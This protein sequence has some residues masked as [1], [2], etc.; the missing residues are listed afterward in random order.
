MD[1]SHV[2]QDIWMLRFAVGQAYAVR[3]PEG[4][5]LVDC[6]SAGS[7]GEI[8]D[9]LA[10][11][12]CAPGELRDIVLTHSHKDHTGA[13]AAVATA[14]GARVLA[15]AA[16]APVIRGDAPEP[17]PVLLDFEV[18]LYE[19]IA[20]TV[21]PAPPSP[22]HRELVD[23]DTLDWGQEARIV[24]VPGHT[25]GSIAVHLPAAGV[26]FTGDTIA[27]H[28]DAVILGVFNVDREQAVASF[29]RQA[30]LDIETACF[31][32]GDPIVKGAGDA[33]R[34]VAADLS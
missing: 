8:L 24:H 15:G 19:S 7:E 12:G 21:P 11:L 34:A 16:D 1:I 32:H 13:A 33:L 14:T 10:G 9:A 26:L 27:S 28:E 17:P 18:P 29:R 22:V 30:A 20:P 25:A 23:G 2:T 31:G 5:A 3:L 4:W 6:G